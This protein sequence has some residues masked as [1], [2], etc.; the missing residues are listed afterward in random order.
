MTNTVSSGF[1]PA[2]GERLDF[3]LRFAEALA[4]SLAEEDNER[5]LT[6]SVSRN[7]GE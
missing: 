2:N 6:E 3:L 5:E 7:D 4:R 1:E